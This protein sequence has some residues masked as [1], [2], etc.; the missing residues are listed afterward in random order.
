MLGTAAFYNDVADGA[1]HPRS[2]GI[3]TK[4]LF[5]L[6]AG[7]YATAY[8]LED[9]RIMKVTE[10]QSD[11]ELSEWLR[12]QRNLPPMFPRIDSVFY[13]L[14]CASGPKGGYSGIIVREDIE[15]YLD[16]VPFGTRYRGKMTDFLSALARIL[17]HRYLAELP[18]FRRRIEEDYEFY[19]GYLQQDPDFTDIYGANWA[20]NVR[21]G[22]DYCHRNNI[23]IDDVRLPNVG[24]RPGT[25]DFVIRDLG[26]SA[27]PSGGEAY[28]DELSGVRRGRR[29]GLRLTARR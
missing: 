16:R 1:G 5:W 3:D 19:L 2:R 15:D 17:N 7:S 25:M 6:G 4:N 12:D 14:P 21:R 29:A 10:D 9:G 28:H 23:T 11:I 8:R 26:V 20:D 18:D 27:T 22:V 13:P 24:I